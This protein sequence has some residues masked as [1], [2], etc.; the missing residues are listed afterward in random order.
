MSHT[1]NIKD[2]GGHC[3]EQGGTTPANCC[4][5]LEMWAQGGQRRWSHVFMCS[6][7]VVE[8]QPLIKHFLKYYKGRIRSKHF[9][10]QIKRPASCS[11]SA[12][13]REEDPNLRPSIHSSPLVTQKLE[14]CPIPQPLVSACSRK[15]VVRGDKDE[16][17]LLKDAHL[18]SLS[19]LY[20]IWNQTFGRLG[21]T[22]LYLGG[23]CMC[24]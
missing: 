8:C 13:E 9:T 23:S 22:N 16:G 19:F 15:D 18:S 7:L 6:S 3:E 5:L 1:N 17:I 10:P 21:Q 4:Q 2:W 24:S 20:V 11:T 12:G 14:L